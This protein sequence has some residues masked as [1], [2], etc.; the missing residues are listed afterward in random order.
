MKSQHLEHLCACRMPTAK[1]R[2]S[3]SQKA[4]A[5]VLMLCTW[6]SALPAQ[7]SGQGASAAAGGQQARGQAQGQTGGGG[8]ARR[9]GATEGAS[10][11]E[12][13]SGS[14]ANLINE[15]QLVGLPLNGRSYSQLAT[16]EAGVSDPS[17]ASA[18]RVCS[19]ATQSTPT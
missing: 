13:A 5:L 11:P 17:A 2:A 19:W 18:S 6:N 16:L 3:Q 4:V 10:V 7:Q 14:K 1:R 8:G 15:N 9:A 12:N